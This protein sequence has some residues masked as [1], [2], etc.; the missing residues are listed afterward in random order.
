[1]ID[2]WFSGIELPLTFEQ[3]RK[4]PTNPAYKYEYF[5]EQAWLTPRP[6]S[7]HVLLKLEPREEFGPGDDRH[8]IVLRSLAAG[9]WDGLDVLFSSAFH[10]VQPFARLSETDRLEAARECLGFT[11]EGGDGPLIGP[12]CFVAV[13]RKDQDP[14][15]VLRGAI[16]VTLMPDRDPSAS[17]D[18][19]WK[20]PPPPDW[21]ERRIGRPH[22]TWIFV[23]PWSTERGVGSAMLSAAINA[24]LAM[25]Y[26]ELASTF[27]MGNDAS[28]LWHWRNGFQLAGRPYSWRKMR[29]SLARRE[30]NPPE[31]SAREPR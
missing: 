6:K 17:F 16:L 8:P 13:A 4:L 19:C 20:E 25:G 29:V 2:R 1:M 18:L 27:L 30:G 21:R 22:L 3:F 14:S 31:G 11:R 12:A 26:R 9:D 5:D 23:G 24:L 10:R 7:C 28:A 15:E